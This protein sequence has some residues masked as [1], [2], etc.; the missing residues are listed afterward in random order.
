MTVGG[1][2]R[3]WLLRFPTAYDG[4]KPRLGDSQYINWG[5]HSV[6]IPDRLGSI[7]RRNGCEPDALSEL[8]TPSVER[9]SWT[10][11]T[12]ADVE[13]VLADG[14]GHSWPG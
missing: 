11:P 3:Y 13:L 6:P 4:E 8:I 9:L 2:G 7:A 12:G 1:V 14:H 5:G 10:C